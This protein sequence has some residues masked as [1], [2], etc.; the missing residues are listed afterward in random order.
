MLSNA[1]YQFRIYNEREREEERRRHEDLWPRADDCE[2]VISK[3]HFADK[4]EIVEP[5][6]YEYYA[7]ER[8]REYRI[9]RDVI[10]CK[11]ETSIDYFRDIF[12]E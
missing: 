1:E 9:V 2:Y 6:I 10:F 5:G 11:F 3:E 8:K 7:E 4:R 12:N